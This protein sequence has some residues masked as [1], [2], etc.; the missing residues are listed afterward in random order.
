LKPVEQ[1]ALTIPNA[2]AAG[3]MDDILERGGRF[4]FR[5]GG[6][7]MVPFVRN[8][9]TLTI[10]PLANQPPRLGDVVAFSQPTE[11]G[12]HLVV[13]RVVGR[14]GTAL[15]VQGDGNGCAPEVICSENVLGRL[16]E[17]ERNGRH[18]RL[19][20]GSER[21]LVAWLSRTRLLW[22]LVWPVWHQ[23]RKLFKPLNSS[24]GSSSSP[25]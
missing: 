12:A 2:A 23:V 11:K 15:V 22:I 20:M 17:V 21:P 8:G 5:A 24:N 9:D 7:S 10:A 4:R 18:V 16:V 6:A 1:K 25:I 14:Q 19:G 13:H 3:L